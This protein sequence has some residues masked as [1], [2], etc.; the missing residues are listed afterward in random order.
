MTEQN[1]PVAVFNEYLKHVNAGDIDTVMELFDDSVVTSEVVAQAYPGGR[2]IDALRRYIGETICQMEGVITASRVARADDWVYGVLEVRSNLL[3][4]LGCERILGI[5][6]LQVK[7][8]R[9]TSFKFLPD[10]TDAQT[11][12]FL[13]AIL[14]GQ[15]SG[16]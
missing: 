6:E 15:Q 4:E 9:I 1:D 12:R 2:H 8:N 5:D 11:Q 7:N 3:K 10:A 14:G 13:K 16:G